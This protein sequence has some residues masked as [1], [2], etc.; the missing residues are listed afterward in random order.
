[1]GRRRAPSVEDPLWSGDSR[2]SILDSRLI[3]Q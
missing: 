3:R 1:V 2:L